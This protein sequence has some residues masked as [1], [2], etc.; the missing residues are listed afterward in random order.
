MTSEIKWGNQEETGN[1]F[2]SVT[3]DKHTLKLKVNLCTKNNLAKSK[4]E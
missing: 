2:R 1:A 3:S 4:Y